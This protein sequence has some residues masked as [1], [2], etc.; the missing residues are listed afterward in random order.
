MLYFGIFCRCT[1]H[2]RHLHDF[3]KKRLESSS[4]A[5]HP[6]VGLLNDPQIWNPDSVDHL[7][8]KL[9]VVVAESN[10]RHSS[11]DMSISFDTVLFLLLLSWPLLRGSRLVCH[12]RSLCQKTPDAAP[13]CGC[14]HD[15]EYA[16][17]GGLLSIGLVAFR[18]CSCRTNSS[19]VLMCCHAH[20]SISWYQRCQTQIDTNDVFVV[21][22]PR[23]SLQPTLQTFCVPQ[24]VQ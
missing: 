20:S 13:S 17:S 9:R 8:L 5:L 14:A 15:K 21:R 23:T 18:L 10:M 7:S 11:Q 6:V 12:S 16:Q 19:W 3:G 2:L 1:D 22:A 4:F 24:A